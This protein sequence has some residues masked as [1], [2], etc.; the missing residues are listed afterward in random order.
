MTSLSDAQRILFES[1]GFLTIPNALAAE[2]LEEVRAAAG[3]A[4][5]KWRADTNRP[6]IRSVALDQVQAPIE[7]E[8]ALLNLLWHPS[9]FP[10]VRALIGDDVMMIDNDLFITP[11]STPHTHANWHHDVGMAGV[12]HPRSLLMLKVFFLLTDVNED[13]GATAMIPGSHRFDEGFVFPKVEDPKSMPGAIQMR[14]KAGDAYLF[15]GRVFHCAVNNESNL[16]RKVLIYNYGHF[17]MKMWQGYEPS[18]RLLEWAKTTCDPV[19][20]QLLG[21]GDAYGQFLT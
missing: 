12:Y 3:R 17:W 4:E 19:K 14:G 13:S 2:E 16:P 20:M 5:Q 18:A 1:Q 10:I 7:Y 9:T 15:N 6:G 21:I 11:P 8:D